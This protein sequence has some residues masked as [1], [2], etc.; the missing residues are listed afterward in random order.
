MAGHA[1]TV[2]VQTGPRCDLDAD[3]CERDGDPD[4]TFQH[5][6]QERVAGVVVRGPVPGETEI[7]EEMPLP[8]VDVPLR[9][10]SRKLVEAGQR[11]IDF[12]GGAQVRGTVRG[13]QCGEAAE[14]GPLPEHLTGREARPDLDAPPRLS[15]VPTVPAVWQPETTMS[16]T[17][18]RAHLPPVGSDPLDVVAAF[19]AWADES[20]RPLYPHQEEAALALAEGDHVVLAT[21]T[22]SG[23]S[24]VAM[25]GIALARNAGVRA[26]WT[27]PIKALVAEKFFDLVD[28]FGADEV[29]LAIG[30]ASINPTCADSRVHGRGPCE[31]GARGG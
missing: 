22:G 3:D 11:C 30:D 15:H 1:D 25:A 10:V 12:L 14:I 19:A 5:I 27:A 18:L 9:D 6:G 21:P 26:V 8:R 4:A 28:L 24:L 31:L 13:E 17:S 2:R 7:D 16:S 20:G 23:K 29:G